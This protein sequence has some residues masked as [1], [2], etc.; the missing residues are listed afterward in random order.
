[1]A[2]LG[3]RYWSLGAKLV[4]FSILFTIAAVATTFLALSLEIRRHSRSG[5]AETLAQ[6]QRMILHLQQ[7]SLGQLLRSSKLMTRARP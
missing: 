5:L 7:E 2:R 3:L 1:M 4:L 6:H